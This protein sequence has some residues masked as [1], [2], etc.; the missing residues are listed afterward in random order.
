L[1]WEIARLRLDWELLKFERRWSRKYRPDQLRD[2]LGRFADEGGQT[3]RVRLAGV[4]KPKL[5][6]A[7]AAAILAEVAQKV[8]D[9]YRS[10]E[11][12]KDLFGRKIGAVTHME[13]DDQ[14]VFGNNSRSPAFDEKVDGSEADRLRVRF[15]EL[16]PDMAE[17]AHSKQMPTD[18]FRH[19][20][21]NV[22]VR[23]ARK[24]GGTLEGRTL[25]VFGDRELCNN[26]K[27]IL[28][29]VGK[30]LG[31]PTVTFFDPRGEVGTIR[32]GKFYPASKR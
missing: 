32:D 10:K 27:E 19:A 30:E 23:A 12:L 2:D 1:R 14:Q 26:C 16:N 4:D 17:K 15:A 22:L 8:I 24:F 18:A 11:G 3:N 13:I 29:F 9:A 31:N 6:P 7:A 25:K 5:G 21:T 20:E 28:G